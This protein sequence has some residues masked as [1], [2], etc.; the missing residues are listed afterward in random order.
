LII[1]SDVDTYQILI[2]LGT[3]VSDLQVWL[4]WRK[5]K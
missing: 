1:S 3:L 4:I 2:I 5:C